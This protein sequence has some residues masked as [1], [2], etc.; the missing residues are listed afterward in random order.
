MECSQIN[1][2]DI[3]APRTHPMDGARQDLS[4]PASASDMSGHAARIESSSKL[5]GSPVAWQAYRDACARQLSL[6]EGMTLLDLTPADMD[7]CVDEHRALDREIQQ[8]RRQA[9]ATGPAPVWL[10]SQEEMV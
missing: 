7:A 9:A 6:W 2:A 10:R 8:L 3:A 1:F 4:A 5:T